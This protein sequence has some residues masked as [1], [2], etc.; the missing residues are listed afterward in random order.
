MLSDIHSTTMKSTMCSALCE[1]PGSWTVAGALSQRC[2][3]SADQRVPMALSPAPQLVLT[4]WLM[5]TSFLHQGMYL[6]STS[7]TLTSDWLQVGTKGT[8]VGE[9][10]EGLKALKDMA[11]PLEDQQCQLT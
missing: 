4:A 5:R 6:G 1:V 7:S 8:P 2:P 11:I 10:R 3:L 9:L